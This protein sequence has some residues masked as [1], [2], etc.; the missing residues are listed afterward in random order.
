MKT[1]LR[2]VAILALVLVLFTSNTM[3]A[4]A[5]T[6]DP[7]TI[8]DSYGALYTAIVEAGDGDVIG[9]K[10]TISIPATIAMDAGDRYIVIKR[11][12][13]DA[14]LLITG[15][16]GEG[17]KA[18]ITQIHFDGNSSG[19]NPVGG[20][21]PFITVSGDV[22]FEN[23]DFE[24]CF[25]EG[26]NGGAVYVESSGN[27]TLSYCRV[28]DNCADYGG[29]IFNKGTLTLENCIL[30]SNWAEETGG[31]IYNAGTLT[32]KNTELK[33]N[34]ARMGGGL[35]NN[36][37]TELYSS[38]VWNNT[39]S[40]HGSD[41]ANEGSLSD[42]TTEEEYNT[43]LNRYSLYFGGWE[44]ELD[45]SI[46]GAGEYKKLLTTDTAPTDPSEPTEPTDPTDPEEPDEG[47]NTGGDTEDG[48]TT[49][50]EDP[51]T[52]DNEE[53][54]T[55]D[56]GDD[57][58]DPSTTPDEGGDNSSG[59]DPVEPDIPSD[60]EQGDNIDNSVTDNSV[61]DNSDHS[62]TDN[63]DHSS[64]DNSATDNSITDNSQSSTDNSV[65]DNSTTDNSTVDNSITDNSTHTEDNSGSG[66]TTDNST[67]SS[68]ADNSQ[69]SSTVDN[70]SVVSNT[71]NS[72]SRSESS[73]TENSN[74]TTT[75]NYYQ[76]E[77]DKGST[78]APQ[79]ISQPITINVT[80]PQA[81]EP[82]TG[83]QEPTEAQSIAQNIHIEAEGVNV[84]YEYTADGVSI[85]ISPYIAPESPTE[86]D[87]IPTAYSPVEMPQEPVESPISWVDYVSMILLAILVLSE[88]RD[89]W[90]RL[91]T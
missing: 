77:Q 42:Y 84:K 90:F 4:S 53:P 59:E 55:P 39:A 75:Y 65:T 38:L 17:A 73:N 78:G 14:K 31:A 13:A 76:T 43:L 36:A 20:T 10:G 32:V 63:S 61:T 41:I 64:T 86:A 34:T 1:K 80:V 87:T 37:S 18:T 11:M 9:V 66:N 70:S 74:N 12:E 58:T 51:D 29:G 50:P 60:T 46:G 33:G 35:Y 45:T 69:H 85:S 27:A 24:D 16:Y 30:E 48:G 21:E 89:R 2:R 8:V 47:D 7:T 19:D 22:L 44:N 81:K 68:T 26:G 91:K 82:E 25:N 28:I 5:T 40:I 6:G 67:H 88:L 57:A 79:S 83:T 62:T 56:G 3:R 23:C 52:G 71:D 54:T 49:T 15:N 72:S